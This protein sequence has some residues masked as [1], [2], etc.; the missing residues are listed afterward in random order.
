MR[1]LRFI[2]YSICSLC[3]VWLFLLL[4]GGPII[5]HVAKIYFGEWIEL[6][7][8]SVSPNLDIS[9]GS[10]EFKADNRGSYSYARGINF[11]WAIINNKPAL[12]F[13]L[14][15]SKLNNYVVFESAIGLV[16]YP[17]TRSW[18]RPVIN[19]NIKGLVFSKPMKYAAK[20]VQYEGSLEL[21]SKSMVDILFKI[22]D[23]TIGMLQEVNAGTVEGKLAKLSLT[24]PLLK[25]EI[26]VELVFTDV[27]APTFNAEQLNTVVK[28]LGEVIS[29][30]GH[31]NHIVV[32]DLEANVGSMSFKTDLDRRSYNFQTPLQVTLYEAHLAKLNF[33]VEKFDMLIEQRFDQFYI[34]GTVNTPQMEIKSGSFYYGTL[35]SSIVN[36]AAEPTTHENLIMI[37]FRSDV[38][39]NE[40]PEISSSANGRVSFASIINSVDCA[41]LICDP[42]N[43]FLNYNLKTVGGGLTGSLSCQAGNCLNGSAGNHIVT[44]Q[45]TTEFFEDLKLSGIFSPIPLAYLYSSVLAGKSVG[46]GHQL[47]F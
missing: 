2:L 39:V 36:F 24:E 22:S 17:M 43:F 46:D 45:N 27:D 34:S 40:I 41:D 47:N 11:G 21:N 19:S 29:L 30:N 25:Q 5:K 8:V 1:F 38:R 12:Q 35:P 37:N 23:T 9:I 33:N 26:E 6:S 42:S 28:S 15:P 32:K 14:G 4:L 7:N 18:K 13:S 10:V 16:S 3:T 44:T 31:S 20:E